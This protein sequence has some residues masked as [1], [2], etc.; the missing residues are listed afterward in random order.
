MQKPQ[1]K[2]KILLLLIVS[3][4]FVSVLNASTVTSTTSGGNWSSGSSW[5]G[6]TIPKSTDE[7][8]INGSVTVDGSFSCIKLTINAGKTLTFASGGHTL[9][10]TNNWQTAFTNNGTFNAGDGTMKFVSSNAGFTV[11]GNVTFNNV[12]LQNI[13]QMN[14]G[15]NATVNGRLIL[16][17]S[18]FGYSNANH[19][20]YGPNAILEVNGTY[21]PST[22]PLIWATDNSSKTAP[23]IVIASGTITAS[24]G[25]LYLKGTLTIHSG[26]TF[27]GSGGCTNMVSGFQGITNNG[28]IS[29]GGVTVKSGA[30]WNVTSN[31]SLA[32]LKIENGGTVNANSYTLTINNGSINNCGGISGIM[33]LE[34]GGVFNA[35]TSTVV[36]N[37]AFNSNVTADV[38][39]PIN[40]NNVVA[41]GS[42]PIVIPTTNTVTIGGNVTVNS[43]ATISNPG[44]IT[45][46]STA[47]VT[48]NG[49]T[50]GTGFPPNV[51]TT[52]PSNN[53]LSG[54]I[55]GGKAG[56]AAI[57]STVSVTLSG[58]LAI[59]SGTS[60]TLTV[61]PGAEL[62]MG[63]YTVTADTVF[64]YGKLNLSNTSGLSGAFLRSSGTPVIV[65]GSGSTIT[66][67]SA[68]EQTITPRS[69]YVHLKLTGNGNKTFAA[70]S[71]S[72]AG[73]FTVSEG[74][75]NITTNTTSFH[76][77]GNSAQ[78]IK[79]LPYKNVSFSGNGNK[80]LTDSAAITGEI[81]L[82]GAAKLISNGLVTLVSNASGT[83]SIGQI[84][85][86]AT[87]IGTV[88]YQRY[89]P[90]GRL[91]RFI[92]WPISGNTFANSWQN[93]IYLTGPGTGGSIGTT[94]SNGFDY[95]STN[96][97]GLYYY[98]EATAATINAKWTTIPN[99]STAI[100]PTRG[101]RVFIRGNRSQG[102]SQL[103][104]SA[105]TP[106]PVT[107]KGTGTPNMGDIPVSLTCS[108]GCG[109]NDGWH[110]LA[111]PYPSAIDW[112][113]ATWVNARS[114]NIVST[115]YVYNPNQNKYGA[116]SPTGGSVNG[117]SSNIASGQSFYVKTN[118]S[119]TLTFKEAYKVNN[120]TA[121]LFGKSSGLQ[122]NLKIKIGDNTKIYDE[123]VV[124]MY[125]NATT[126]LDQDLDAVKPDV[127]NASI[128]T[129]SDQN[130]SKLIF[131]AIPELINGDSATILIHL[132][133]AN[134][135]YTYNL[136]F[137]GMTTFGNTTTQF[138]LID[139]YT[140]SSILISPTTNIYSFNTTANTAASYA[141]NRFILKITTATGSL[142]VKM[143]A[144]SGT[145]D[146]GTAVIKWTTV[147]ELNNDH[148][149]IQRSADGI[150]YQTI[151]TVAGAMN[152]YRSLAYSFI[153][154]TPNKGINYY[155]LNQIDRDGTSTLSNVISLN[156]AKEIQATTISA[157]PIPA[158]DYITLELNNEFTTTAH[159]VIRDVIGKVIYEE[160]ILAD[161]AGYNH[162]ISLENFQ[163][164]VYFMEVGQ[165]AEK[166]Q[167]I[168]FIKN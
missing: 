137:D 155:R 109:V 47:T 108:N 164:G 147:T 6:G 90:A 7:A 50:S 70:G 85:G 59:N 74:A 110:L 18:D 32:T 56:A 100:D 114:A 152:S 142:P 116:W 96:E 88:N 146:N 98:N 149:D 111:N 8:V 127:G 72:I 104:G 40:F 129:Y 66:Y 150:T 46:D 136:S 105:Y 77:N 68:V 145:K 117:G 161:E 34:S 3:T 89:I 64:I 159:I 1:N 134:Y 91:W 141:S 124:Y 143:T 31:F 58:N 17:G 39:G 94:N 160:T 78:L 128:S 28:T 65:I 62:T 148:F 102:T 11:S 49:S 35:G 30:V 115:V 125:P 139:N 44:N 43:G 26:A 41:S 53:N 153:D 106:L 52:P 154:E 54:T 99:T 101:Y 57:Q 71:Y 20:I 135:T 51:E 67:N 138:I 37:P 19:P 76:F 79:G 86:T 80:T 120:G 167:S 83:A 23:N 73:D 97:A 119:A 158:N 118:G 13:T 130:S 33:Q 84:S 82:S 165:N 151:G 107:L 92:G 21:S 2:I 81:T 42:A 163:S 87:I 131:N 15:G 38:S 166:L 29:L 133:L 95:T 63:T 16:N 162:P 126:D 55:S 25:Q 60:K 69:D 122:N 132:P 156:F 75:A 4:L 61:A 45:F 157:W 36:F 123:T 103:S 14:M 24:Q 144:F 140:N 113:N 121:G 168:K 9:T 48:N 27:N 22:N 93:D 12:T 10:I 5:V 112:N